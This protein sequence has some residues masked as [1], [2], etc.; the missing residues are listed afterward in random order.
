MMRLTLLLLL[1]LPAT[2]PAQ[3]LIRV[4][5]GV[6]ASSKLVEDF[7]G[8]P[9]TVTQAVPLPTVAVQ[10][11]HTLPS[12]YRLGVE[13][14]LTSGTSEVTDDGTTEDLGTV[15]TVSVMAL[16]DGPVRGP[17]R[18]QAGVGTILYR[19][20]EETGIW[21]RGG[22]SRWLVGGGM[23]WT[24]PMGS[25]DLV[26]GGRYDFHPFS[27]PRLDSDG[28]GGYQAVHRLGLTLGLERGF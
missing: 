1:A 18:W 25:V 4:S 21:G 16:A 3:T 17:L 2:V 15:R 12:G 27:T 11:S 7:L 22:A 9:I 24:R 23:T 10:L 5:A 13:G 28:Y 19:P 6:T 8:G 26:V 14:R 20:A